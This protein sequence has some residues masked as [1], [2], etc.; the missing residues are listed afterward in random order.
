MW[1]V[2]SIVSHPHV[3]EIT[4]LA[5]EVSRVLYLFPDRLIAEKG[6]VG[7]EEGV[8][9]SSPMDITKRCLHLGTKDIVLVHNHPYCGKRCDPHPSDLDVK[10]TKRYLWE[11]W[12]GGV[13]LCDH[14]IVSPVGY[15]SF[16]QHGLLT[17]F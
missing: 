4:G 9:L 1:N 8:S 13:R 11:L 7:N 15:F 3:R 16:C 12:S 10:T 2:S 6:W 14:I 5:F 17:F